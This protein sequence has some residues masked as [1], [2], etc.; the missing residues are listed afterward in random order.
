MPKAAASPEAFLRTGLAR[1]LAQ[2]RH[3]PRV[4]PAPREAIRAVTGEVAPHEMKRIVSLAHTWGLAAF[5][6][7]PEPVPAT[8]GPH[9]A[10][11]A[12]SD[13]SRLGLVGLVAGAV[14]VGV[15]R[16]GTPWLWQ[17]DGPHRG[18]VFGLRAKDHAIDA[19]FASPAA[20]ALWLGAQEEAASGGD[21]RALI[22]VACELPP[23]LR[24]R[25]EARVAR[26]AALTLAVAGSDAEAARA[27]RRLKTKLAEGSADAA[28]L[29]ALLYAWVTDDGAR[30]TQLLVTLRGSKSALYRDAAATLRALGEP[31][32]PKRSSKWEA[33]LLARRGAVRS[34][35]PASTRPTKD[36]AR[37]REIVRWLD[38]TSGALEPLDVPVAREEALLALGELAS[39]QIFPELV[40]RARDGDVRAVEMLAASR[41]QRAAVP[42]LLELLAR[43]SGR[44]RWLEAAVVRALAVLDARRA[45]PALREL[46]VESPLRTWREGIERGPLVRELVAALGRMQDA[47]AGEIILPLL[48]SRSAEYKALAPTAAHALGRI[49]YAPAL[50]TLTEGVTSTRDALSPE[51]VWAY[52]H[53]ALAAGVGAQA[54]RVLDAVTTL[55]PTIEVLRQGAI[56]LVAPEKRGPRR[57]EAFRLA[58]ERALWEPAFRQEDTSRRRA[59]AFR[60]L[61]D[62]ATA[63]AAPHIGAETVRYFVTLDDHRVRRAATHAFGACGLSVPKTRRYYS[64][65]LADI[66]RRGGREALHAALRD[67]LG[68]FRYNIATYLGD[69][70]DAASARA[71][72]AAAAAAFSEPPT[73]AYE[74]D[75]APRHLEA[76]A[77]ALAKLNTPEGNDVLIEALRSGNHQVRA[78]VAEH[79]PPDERIVPELLMMLEDPRSFLRSRAERA[80]ESMRTGTPAPPD[81]SRIRLVEG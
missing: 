32:R 9:L 66:E 72:A 68:V 27:A 3:K 75:D 12:R 21:A 60:A 46:L 16:D 37:A 23:D 4:T 15:R 41:D 14:P 34:N 49:G 47:K 38:E 51:L 33:R 73:T 54:A 25:M 26:A 56:L 43:P 69:L 30:L 1:Y 7:R 65:V 31:G 36:L 62:A 8:L 45:A 10:A 57:R 63:G 29:D 19:L 53:V 6:C 20:F 39:P 70:G 5:R 64:F 81:P 55:D 79:A 52:G 44:Y 22:A 24:E 74:Y 78:V 18:A 48:Q 11:A 42:V 59:W 80:L 35:G 71:V 77:S 58:L 67:P 13:A 28:P 40:A 61:V 17:F 2:R 50:D 76:F